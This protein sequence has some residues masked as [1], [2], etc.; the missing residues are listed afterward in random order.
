M[1][2]SSQGEQNG[3]G[4][5]ERLVSP[6]HR[7]QAHSHRLR[8]CAIITRI[9]PARKTRYPAA[10]ATRITPAPSKEGNEGAPDRR[11][12]QRERRDDCRGGVRSEDLESLE[13]RVA[14]NCRSTLKYL[15]LVSALVPQEIQDFV[16]VPGGWDRGVGIHGKGRILAFPSPKKRRGLSKL[17][18][19]GAAA[20]R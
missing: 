17:I 18:T 15:E 11:H 12:L 5:A 6:A 16:V 8:R 19:R 10:A 20:T 9:A 4:V 1:E 3:V 13:R 7:N 2:S 14:E